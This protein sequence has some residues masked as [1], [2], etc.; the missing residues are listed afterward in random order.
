[1]RPTAPPAV[2]C[3]GKG[4]RHGGQRPG[5]VLGRGD[6]RFD[7]RLRHPRRFRPRRRRALWHDP[8]RSA[9]RPHDGQHRAVL[10]WQRDLAGGR[11]RQSLRRFPGSLRG[12]SRRFLPA[13]AAVAVRAD[14]SRRRFRVSL[15][16]RAPAQALGSRLLAWLNAGRLRPGRCH[17]RDDARHSGRRWP[18]RWWPV[19]LAGSLSD[20]HRGRPGARLRAARRELAGAQERRR[21]ARVGLPSPSGPGRRCAARA[22]PGVRRYFR[23]QRHRTERAARSALGAGFPG[24]RRARSARRGAWCA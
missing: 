16:Q 15:S 13:G 20:P 2:A 8:R 18:V 22:L 11:R 7:P 21:T 5:I 4:E 23:R 1:M 17:R 9:A 3:R 6:S 14:L 24:A 10:G 12:V 19:A